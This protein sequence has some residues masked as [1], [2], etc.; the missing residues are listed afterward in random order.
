MQPPSVCVI[1]DGRRTS[2]IVSQFWSGLF[3]GWYC[4]LYPLLDNMPQRSEQ[5]LATGVSARKRMSNLW[6]KMRAMMSV[7]DGVCFPAFFYFV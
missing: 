7:F 1:E 2:D 4:E 5:S 3:A 6:V